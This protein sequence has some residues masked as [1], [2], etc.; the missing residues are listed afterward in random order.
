MNYRETID[1]LYRMLPAYQR[2]GAAA[3]KK[4]L[5]NIRELC[6]LLGHPEGGFRSIHIA[7]TNGKGSVSHM[8]ASVLAE[9]GYRTGLYTSPH[10]TD[11]RERIRID[12][13]M[14]PET[15]VVDFV[16]R[17]QPAI[18]TLKPSFFEVTVAMAFD[19]FKRHAADV[20]V[21]ETGLGGRLDSTNILQ[22]E[23]AVITNIGLDHM[24]LLGDT[25]PEIAAEKAGI[26][27]QGVPALIGLRQPETEAVFAQTAQ[28]RE[29]PLHYAEELA[30]CTSLHYA[31]GRRLVR[32]GWHGRL[33]LPEFQL[34]LGGI[35]Q[36]ENTRTALAA[37]ALLRKLR[38]FD[39]PDGAVVQGLSDVRRNTGFTGRWQILATEPLTVMDAGHNPPGIRETVRQLLEEGKSDWRIIF[40][41][42]RD[43]DLNSVLDVL[44]RN[45]AYYLTQPPAERALPVS[46][47]V[48]AFLARGMRVVHQSPD[49][50]ESLKEATC[51]AGAD[52]L[53]LITG[54]I[55]LL[56]ALLPGSGG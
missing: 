53:V 8:L 16:Q 44:P 15:E 46:E 28:I 19:H 54:S 55:F 13:K 22:P 52:S 11:F 25:L 32:A 45:A 37:V 18:E 56:G 4:D 2:I 7:G 51:D 21:V 26:I 42:V 12:G 17:I 29:S 30:H 20:A 1:Y 39:L 36:V 47:L 10:L 5:T 35:Y 31:G 9:A 43:K 23:L 50:L 40:G 14:I 27:K 33:E 3:I 6:R 34:D 38:G 48:S 24:H 49:P 41:C